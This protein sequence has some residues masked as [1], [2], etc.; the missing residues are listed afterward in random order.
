MDR[1]IRWYDYITMN[2]YF[3]ALTTLSNFL[4]SSFIG[5][6]VRGNAG[7]YYGT[8]AVMMVHY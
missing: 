2:A 6:A 4:A 7:T 5:A 3:L 8:P 1:P